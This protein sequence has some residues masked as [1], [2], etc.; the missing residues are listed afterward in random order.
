MQ[1]LILHIDYLLRH[2]DCVIVP[3]IGAFIAS[4]RG[5][6]IGADGSI[7]PP[8]RILVFNPTVNHNDGLLSAS[9]A[10][11]MLCGAS[12]ASAAL[13]RDIEQL[14]A[15]LESGASVAIGKHG[16]LSMDTAGSIAFEAA[17]ADS[18]MP[19]LQMQNILDMA[20]NDEENSRAGSAAVRGE[21]I[22]A[23]LRR[24]KVAAS[25]AVILVL[26]FVLSTPTPIENAQF[27]SPV[28]EQ[29]KPKMPQSECLLR[30]PG[31]QYGALQINRVADTAAVIHADTAAIAAHKAELLRRAEELRQ[32]AAARK[33]TQGRY[34][35]VVASLNSGNEAHK[36]L[37][38]NSAMKLHVLENDGRYRVYALSGNSINDVKAKAAA[39]GLFERFP[40]AWVC[41]R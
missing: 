38:A 16:T 26:G 19:V 6:S 9:Y 1:E 24:I 36:F 14:R 39:A 7:C 32:T 34:C 35:L 3:G 25:I 12:E 40:G 41:R 5:A 27:A 29:F 17:K 4:V 31:R 37:T 28:V 2:H 23:Y 15:T 13:A 33:N 21:H 10:R 18:W 8:A 30:Q 22:A 11:R 20:R